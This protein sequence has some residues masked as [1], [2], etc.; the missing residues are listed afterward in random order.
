MYGISA[1]TPP[2]ADT[3]TGNERAS[4]STYFEIQRIAAFVAEAAVPHA[5]G[6]DP[7]PRL[8]VELQRVLR[9]M[10]E[11]RIP[12]ELRDALLTGAVLG[13]EA[14]RWLPAIRRW[15]ADEC[16]RSGV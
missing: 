5:N 6:F 1:V 11:D 7:G 3:L 16:A 10:P 4:T 12:S 8:R 14:A 15:L 2:G 13:S 9:D